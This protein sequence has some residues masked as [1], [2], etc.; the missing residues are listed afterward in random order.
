MPGHQTGNSDIEFTSTDNS[1]GFA[2]IVKGFKIPVPPGNELFRGMNQSFETLHGH[3]W[4]GS[5]ARVRLRCALRSA[6]ADRKGA[7]S[8]DQP[9]SSSAS[10]LLGVSALFRLQI[11]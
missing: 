2:N 4:H 5:S 9:L 1:L 7:R 6:S 11:L 3:E 10:P 8:D